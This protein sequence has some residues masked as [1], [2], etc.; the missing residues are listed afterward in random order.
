MKK[1]IY[2]DYAAA[3]YVL[4]E[5]L[6]VMMPYFEEKYGNPS[7][8]HHK[9][10][11]ARQAVDGARAIVAKILHAEPREIIFTG[12]GTESDNLAI[13]GVFRAAVS[14]PFGESKLAKNKRPHIIT[15]AVEHS[16]VL[17]T[18]EYLEKNY[19]CDVTYV[20]VDEYGM[21]DPAKVKKALR[22]NTIL[23]TIMYANNEVGTINAISEIGKICQKA[24]V[25]FHTDACQAAGTL[26]M[27]VRKLNVDLLTLNGS[28]IYGPKGIG[29]LYKK[30]SIK[31]VPLIFGGEGQEH[32]LRAG[33]ENVPAIVGLAKAFEIAQENRL[34]E[35]TRLAE[36]RD[37]LT[38]ELLACIP[39]SFLNGYPYINST[40]LALKA[41][42]HGR[43]RLPNNVNISFAGIEGETLLIKLDELGICATSGSACTS[44]SLD[45]SHVLLAMGRSTELA[46]GALRLTLG[47]STTAADVKYVVDTLPRVIADLR[48]TS[49]LYCSL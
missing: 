42:D 19:G 38:K 5:V 45:P 49:P 18:C 20:E 26:E 24:V 7:S 9:G 46:N 29:V 33:T 37:I 10:Q 30:K 28:K 36:L 35:N 4:P 44:G 41:N 22:E 23:C 25:P 15:S 6:E 48:K 12:S 40:A 32:R 31:L 11:E 1:T 47:R 3:T 39:D 17:R 27:D 16:A 43:M 8:I 21:V 2:L 14:G 34:K 13:Q